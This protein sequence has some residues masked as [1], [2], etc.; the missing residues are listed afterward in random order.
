M[1]F[2][3][4]RRRADI[5]QILADM[6]QLESAFLT[7]SEGLLEKRQ[8]LLKKRLAKL[9]P[10]LEAMYEAGEVEDVERLLE[11]MKIPSSKEWAKHLTSLMDSSAKAGV[12]RAHLEMLR[13]KELYEFAEGDWSVDVNTG[14]YDF[15][16]TFPPE[17]EAW[18]KNRGYEIG[19]ITDE[20][21]RER[22]REA[23][24]KN[25]K[26][27]KRGSD[28]TGEINAVTEAWVNINH[29][30][31]I[32]RTET[33]KMYNAGRLARWLDPETNGFVVALQYD[34]I[35]DMRTT[36]LCRSLDGK[37]VAISNSSAI[38]ELTPPNHYRCRA[39]WLPV[40]KYEDF[41]DD[42]PADAK[43]Q[44]GFDFQAPLPA[45]IKDKKVS[46][47]KPVKKVHPSLV[48]DPLIIRNLDDADF[49]I[50]IGNITDRDM[51]YFLIKERAEQMVISN[52]VLEV[53]NL[54]L[55]FKGGTFTDNKARFKMHPDGEEFMFR[56]NHD[57]EIPAYELMEKLTGMTDLKEFDSV[58]DKFIAEHDGKL[59]Y[60]SAM[61]ALKDAKKRGL[62]GVTF[63]GLPEVKDRTPEVA[64]LLTYKKPANTAN[65]RNATELKAQIEES[66]KWLAKYV[67]N[68][69][70]PTTPMVIR[71]KH[72]NPRAYAS[73]AKSEIHIG[74]RAAKGTM[75]H[76]AGHLMHTYNKPV[77]EM[78]ETFFMRR[79]KNMTIAKDALYGEP[80]Y[81]DNFYS[82][83][84]GRVYGWEN[85]GTYGQE[86]LSMGIQAMQVDPVKFY[87]DDKEHFLFTFAILGGLF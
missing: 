71:F 36:D 66:E 62:T 26:T 23:T 22:I 64:K 42:F 17:A 80:N 56:L 2:G 69:L 41:I 70:A 4:R 18:I 30:E 3:E 81:P 76:E 60:T 78:V 68:K 59:Y 16:V 65:Y 53:K 6:E 13:L 75:T 86:V 52:K 48:T 74:K 21:I 5:K 72:D 10:Q 19:V 33:A 31:T 32:A 67:D 82:A 85:K 47:V 29:A 79:T 40:T 20:T 54:D 37:I 11:T 44:A 61:Q 57:N 12:L 43:A 25:L 15:E 8:T 7:N 63:N 9:L 14:G 73:P 87:R 49:K 28:L 55:N 1:T 24:L 34:A 27:G 77:E 84:V 45:L 46:L 50:A 83:Y 51:K 58:V 39:T 35:V 38:A